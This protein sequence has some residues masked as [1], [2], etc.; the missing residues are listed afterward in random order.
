MIL[1]LHADSAETPGCRHQNASIKI[2]VHS[3]KKV[4]GDFLKSNFH[5]NV[6]YKAN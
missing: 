1:V 6:S 4:S 3:A 5:N 2:D